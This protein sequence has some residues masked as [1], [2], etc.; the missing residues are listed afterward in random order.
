MERVTFFDPRNPATWTPREARSEAGTLLCICG[1]PGTEFFIDG[2]E[3]KNGKCYGILRGT[4]CEEHLAL[5]RGADIPQPA[6]DYGPLF[7]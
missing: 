2:S 7:G 3:I 5:Y 1:K 4:C 6:I